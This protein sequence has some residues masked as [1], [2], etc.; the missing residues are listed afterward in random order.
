MEGA[1][2]QLAYLL[3]AKILARLHYKT[4][5]AKR[6]S[7]FSSTSRKHSFVLTYRRHT[8]LRRRVV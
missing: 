5:V 7:V 3:A 2:K 4:S 6:L 8:A 1:R